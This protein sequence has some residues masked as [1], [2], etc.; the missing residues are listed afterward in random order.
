MRKLIG[1]FCIFGGLGFLLYVMSQ[2]LVDY[3]FSNVDT[4]Q[5]SYMIMSL[6]ALLA[7]SSMIFSIYFCY[8]ITNTDDD[9]EERRLLMNESTYDPPNFDDLCRTS[10]RISPR[11][12]F[13]PQ[14]SPIEEMSNESARSSITLSDDVFLPEDE[15]EQL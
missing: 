14:L 5:Y 1:F 2:T 15:L 3:Y 10:T 13:R 11:N 8:D 6:G 7:I 4:P 9:D 12:M